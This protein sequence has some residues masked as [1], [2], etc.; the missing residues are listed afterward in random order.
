MALYFLPAKAMQNT[1]CELEELASMICGF[2]IPVSGF[3]GCPFCFCFMQLKTT[4]CENDSIMGFFHGINPMLSFPLTVL[5]RLKIL[6]MAFK[7]LISFQTLK[8]L[9]CEF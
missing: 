2:R 3:L 8:I 1:F 9:L 6:D 7:I 4:V 5:F